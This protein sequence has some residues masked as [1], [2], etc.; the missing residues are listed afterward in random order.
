MASK[1]KQKKR[2]EQF[3]AEIHD[4]NFF[5]PNDLLS[6]PLARAAYSDRTAWLMAKA[7]KL[8]Y[9]R[10]EKNEDDRALLTTR[11]AD[12]G[13]QLL[14]TFAADGTEAFLAANDK[15]A[16]LAF[17]GTECDDARDILA[18]LRVRFYRPDVS[19]KKKGKIHTGFNGAYAKIEVELEAAVDAL[20]G[21]P[22]YITGHSLGGAVATVAARENRHD[23]VAAVYTFG[24]P[25]VGC[26]DL[27][28][29]LKVPVYRVVYRT[30]LIARVPF[31]AMGY[32]HAGHFVYIR[33]DGRVSPSAG[34]SR[35]AIPFI[36]FS[37]V[38][39]FIKPIR[40]HRIDNYIRDLGA[41]ATIRTKDER[42]Q[43]ELAPSLLRS[44]QKSFGE[45]SNKKAYSPEM[46]HRLR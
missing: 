36:F 18:D 26:G 34:W 10:F 29:D 8:A 43:G 11:L 44:G 33:G 40:D 25:R 46:M 20:D 16:I 9:L 1:S 27:E 2:Q 4:A 13:F 22:L 37:V 5:Q 42:L 31:K 3:A 32:R 14:R 21:L 6:P 38:T 23:N 39:A 19:S 7:S 15:M 12:G 41:Y 24:C 45:Q 17:R 35:Q 28:I 30:D